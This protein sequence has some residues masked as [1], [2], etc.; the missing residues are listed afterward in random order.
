MDHRKKGK[1]AAG[2]PDWD[3]PR[4][5]RL[6]RPTDAEPG[7]EEKIAVMMERLARREP[8]C[9]PGD[10]S[11]VS[12]AT[13]ELLGKNFEFAT[14]DDG[15]G[16]EPEADSPGDRIRRARLRAGLG[17]SEAAALL[18]VSQATVSAVETRAQEPSL[19]VLYRA[20]RAFGVAIGWLACFQRSA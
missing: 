2:R 6:G 11:R 14:L 15:P 20:S 3:T 16:P 8:L 18:G 12:A 1:F 13:L 4:P 19:W 10:R 5:A 9:Q 7:S 17:Q